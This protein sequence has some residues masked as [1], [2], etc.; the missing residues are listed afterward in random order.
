MTSKRLFAI[1]LYR[2]GQLQ[3]DGRGRE[4]KLPEILRIIADALEAGQTK[5]GIVD[6]RDAR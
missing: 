2:D 1:T 3:I 4:D 6:D 5:L